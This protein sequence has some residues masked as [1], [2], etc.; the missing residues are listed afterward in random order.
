MDRDEALDSLAAPYA[1]ALRLADAGGTHDEIAAD[2]GIEVASVAA[3]LDIGAGK[4]ARAMADDGP[5]P[6]AD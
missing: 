6:P 5:T 4:L 1:R 2:L 3:L